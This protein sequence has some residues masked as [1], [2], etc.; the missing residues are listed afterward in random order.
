MSVEKIISELCESAGIVENKGLTAKEAYNLGYKAYYQMLKTGHPRAP[1]QDKELMS[2]LP[3]GGKMGSSLPILDAWN[4][5][6]MAALK[7]ES[8]AEIKRLGIF[9]ASPSRYSAYRDSRLNQEE[10]AMLK[11]VILM[12]ENEGRFYE[13]KD[14]KGAVKYAI[15]EYIKNKTRSMRESAR[16]IEKI[17]VKEVLGECKETW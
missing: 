1:A 12:A 15:S 16:L 14:A 9:E 4:K 5:G 13:R 6:Y 10:E 11:E 7:K 3:K 2:R 17:A 8:D